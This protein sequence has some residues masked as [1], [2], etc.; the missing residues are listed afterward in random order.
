MNEY[1]RCQ[2]TRNFIAIQKA[3]PSGA[4]SRFLYPVLTGPLWLTAVWIEISRF[5]SLKE[6]GRRFDKEADMAC[7]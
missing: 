6:R 4:D 1:L 2:K 5:V 3:V 7:S